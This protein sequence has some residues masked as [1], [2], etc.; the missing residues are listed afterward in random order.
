MLKK[1]DSK[2]TKF[3]RVKSAKKD[4][5]VFSLVNNVDG[6]F[7]SVPPGCEFGLAPQTKM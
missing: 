1:Q 5:P 6:M 2:L 4:I 7:I 3:G